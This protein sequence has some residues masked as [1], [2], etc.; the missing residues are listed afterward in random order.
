M[1]MKEH[2]SELQQKVI[3]LDHALNQARY[4][5]SERAVEVCINVLASLQFIRQEHAK[6]GALL[7]YFSC[8]YYY[9]FFFLGVQ[10]MAQWW[11]H[12]PPTNV[13]RVRFLDPASNVGWVCWFSSLHREVFSGYSGFPSPQKPKFEFDLIVLI[14][15]FVL[16]VNFV[17]IVNL[18]YSVPN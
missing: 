17:L 4:E 1:T 3:A 11:E 5:L 12:S 9:C 13:A 6:S 10:G 15:N 16:N 14:V 7:L 2:K 18:I 8:Y